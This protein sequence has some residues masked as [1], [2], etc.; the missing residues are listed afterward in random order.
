M[1]DVTQM[2]ELVSLWALISDVQ[3][4]QVEDEIRDGRLAD[5]TQRARHM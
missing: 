3:L 2:A 5:S 4:T 1:N